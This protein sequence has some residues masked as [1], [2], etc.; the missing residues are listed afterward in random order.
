MS[1]LMSSA[2]ARAGAVDVRPA[3]A[4][5]AARG[6]YNRV[7]KVL[8]TERYGVSIPKGDTRLVRKVNAALRRLIADGAGERNL[9][10]SGYSLSARPTPGTG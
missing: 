5:F 7:P 3:A 2:S 6:K 10:P 9:A 1:R 4:G 8:S